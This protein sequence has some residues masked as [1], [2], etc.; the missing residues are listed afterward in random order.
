MS[1]ARTRL[2]QERG[3]AL[4]EFALALIPLSLMILAIV[5]FGFWFQ[6]RSALRD[7]VRAAARQAALCRSETSPT[8]QSVYHGIVD[9]S[10]SNPPDAVVSFN[11]DTSATCGDAGTPVTVTGSY[12]FS[13][14]LLG[15]V[16]IPASKLTATAEAV[17]E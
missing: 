10:M 17:V 5:E 3:Q 2:R 7:G 11:G 13:V 16:V 15:I 14:D 9:S 6:A 1:A 8:P 12:S 4:V